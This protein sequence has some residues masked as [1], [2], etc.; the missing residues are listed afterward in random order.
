MRWMKRGGG[1]RQALPAPAAE[2]RER[3]ARGAAGEATHV[4]DTFARV[5]SQR[6]GEQLSILLEAY[7][8]ERAYDAQ[9]LSSITGVFAT[10]IGVLSVVGSAV[11]F[12]SLHPQGLPSL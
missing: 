4:T 1:G 11:A 5:E 7:N 6:R 3:L 8:G 9:T 12:A 2:A 10:I